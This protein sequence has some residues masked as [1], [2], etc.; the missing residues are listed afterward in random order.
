M[1]LF[2]SLFAAFA[3][4]EARKK[5]TPE[6]VA[7]E[8]AVQ[9]KLQASSEPERPLQGR[10]PNHEGNMGKESTELPRVKVDIESMQENGTPSTSSYT[11]MASSQ[12]AGSEG[13]NQQTGLN[14]SASSPNFSNMQPE[15]FELASDYTSGSDVTFAAES[16]TDIDRVCDMGST[17][18]KSWSDSCKVA[19]TLIS[20]VYKK[21]GQCESLVPGINRKIAEL[22]ALTTKTL[23]GNKDLDSELQVYKQ[24]VD[25]L[26]VQLHEK[27]KLIDQYCH[28]RNK[29]Q[30]LGA[31]LCKD[32]DLPRLQGHQ[33]NH[34]W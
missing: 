30:Q 15:L 4:M 12:N 21:T 16:E 22:V 23:A 25:L 13:D 6:K 9:M 7:S 8:T 28:P 3:G 32:L 29:D 2:N 34:Q 31:K 27:A 33:D 24:R 5:K 17:K 18:G 20:D 19:L 10:P 14:R 1:T 11:A 26:E